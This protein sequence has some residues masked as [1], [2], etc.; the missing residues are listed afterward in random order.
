[1]LPHLTNKMIRTHLSTMVQPASVV[2]LQR[3]AQLGGQG[4]GRNVH[5][6]LGQ[7]DGEDAISQLFSHKQSEHFEGGLEPKR[8]C[9]DQHLL[10]TSRV[11]ALQ[12]GQHF[13]TEVVVE[14]GVLRAK[15][16]VDEDQASA[17]G[18]C[19]F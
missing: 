11:G 7:A 13:L 14:V 1:M 2:D 18:G 8:C 12:Q 5:V 19:V 4:R 17:L 9:H 16:V 6:Q 15:H 10:E 3:P